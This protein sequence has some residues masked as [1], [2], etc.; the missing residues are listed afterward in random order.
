[1]ISS[2]D[3][4]YFDRIH[5]VSAEGG[6]ISRVRGEM[7]FERDP[8]IRRVLDIGCGFGD[9]LKFMSERKIKAVGVDISEYALKQARQRT[10]AQLHLVDVARQPL[11]FPDESFDAVTAFDL[12]EHI[13]SPKRL[14]WEIFRVLRPQGW[15]FLTTPNDQGWLRKILVRLF[16]DDPTHVNVRQAWYWKDRL[17]EVGFSDVEVRG[18][19]LH[20]FPPFPRL[21]RWLR[22]AGI[23]VFLGPVFFSSVWLTG[24]LYIFARK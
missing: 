9:F 11:P 21:R 13:Q 5:D 19:I 8:T 6:A 14:F 18:A 16:P 23:P 15:I 17:A 2:Y 7:L 12:V 22:G 10:T 24:T 1:M 3:K 4:E 20:G